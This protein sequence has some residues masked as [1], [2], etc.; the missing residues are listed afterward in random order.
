MKVAVGRVGVNVLVHVGVITPVAVAEG[1]LAGAIMVGANKS[2]YEHPE[3]ITQKSGI[4]RWNFIIH[5]LPR[6][7]KDDLYC[8]IKNNFRGTASYQICPLHF[9]V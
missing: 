9:L 3:R 2:V 7:S 4:N 5:P 1:P 8:S 6:Q